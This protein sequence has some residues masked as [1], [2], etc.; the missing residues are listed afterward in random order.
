M[1]AIYPA[2]AG[3]AAAPHSAHVSSVLRKLE[4]G[5]EV[6]LSSVAWNDAINQEHPTNRAILSIVGTAPEMQ[7]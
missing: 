2:L 3:I 1:H 4:F 5:L 6:G 7:R